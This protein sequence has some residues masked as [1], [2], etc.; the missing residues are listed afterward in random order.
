MNEATEADRVLVLNDGR[1]VLSGTPEEVF[2]EVETLW[3]IGLDVPQ[4]AELLHLLNEN[5]TVRKTGILNRGVLGE[6]KTVT[7]LKTL[8]ETLGGDK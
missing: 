1:L 7:A 8:L 3:E 2:S 6:D 5:E 4:T